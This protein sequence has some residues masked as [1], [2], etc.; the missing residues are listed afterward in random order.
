MGEFDRHFKLMNEKKETTYDAF[1][2]G[3]HSSVGDEAIK[4]I[5][6]AL[7]AD[8]FKFSRRHLGDHEPR[9]SYAKKTLSST[10]FNKLQKLWL[11]YE[12]LGYDGTNGFRAKQAI[13]IMN[14][15]LQF[16][17]KRWGV[18]IEIRKFE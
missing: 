8:A 4:S 15:L 16:F 3:N 14:D 13:T 7:E 18:K 11:T 12:D 6:Q 17:E 1:A 9:F 2:K 10:L 5:E